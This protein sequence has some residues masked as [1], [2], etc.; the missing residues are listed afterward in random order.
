MQTFARAPSTFVCLALSC[1]LLCSVVHS[2]IPTTL[3]LAAGECTGVA[4]NAIGQKFH[5]STQLQVTGDASCISVSKLYMQDACIDKRNNGLGVNTVKQISCKQAESESSETCET[6][7]TPGAAPADAIVNGTE[8]ISGTGIY[9]SG[10]VCAAETNGF[11]YVK[12]TCS[13]TTVVELTMPTSDYDGAPCISIAGRHI[14]GVGIALIV[15]AI[16]VVVILS[17]LLCYCCCCRW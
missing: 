1:V 17:A 8:A 4:F 11:I 13:N 15:A 2:A 5:Y 16:L 10:D 12:S 6:V 14:G 3:T 7:F 9:D